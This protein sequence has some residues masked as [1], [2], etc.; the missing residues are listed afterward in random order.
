[1]SH[2]LQHGADRA[3]RLARAKTRIKATGKI[4][5]TQF[6]IVLKVTGDVV[7]R[8]QMLEDSFDV[9]KAACS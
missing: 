7:T 8:F 9:L 1:M 6:A 4:I 2:T 3:A 5:A